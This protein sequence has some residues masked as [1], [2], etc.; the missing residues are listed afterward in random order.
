MRQYFYAVDGVEYGPVSYQELLRLRLPRDSKVWYEGL[1]G[2]VRADKLPALKEVPL[3]LAK[4]TVGVQTGQP[5][6]FSV[7]DADF[8]I[9]GKPKNYKIFAICVLVFSLITCSIFSAP[10]AITTMV[11]S[12]QVDSKYH[13]GFFL[14]AENMSKYTKI[15]L[16]V[17]VG[18][19]VTGLVLSGIPY[20][21]S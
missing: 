3:G 7:L 21:F 2:W 13:N 1:G 11:F 17:T 14:A 8:D 20:L 15:G 9:D 12:S 19:L 6:S 4:N 5:A 10:F 16:M 18:M